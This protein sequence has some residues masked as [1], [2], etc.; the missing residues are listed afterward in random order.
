MVS[1]FRRTF[2][3]TLLVV[4]VVVAAWW[5]GVLDTDSGETSPDGVGGEEW[6][7]VTVYDGDTLLASRGSA[8]EKVRLIG[9]DAPEIGECGYEEARDALLDRV[10]RGSVVLIPGAETDRDRYERLLRYVE[11]DGEDVGLWLIE[12]GLAKARYDRRTGQPHD[13]E[14]Q[15]MAAD[16]AAAALCPV[17][18]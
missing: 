13:R 3:P 7:V 8:E 10:G 6:R 5:L 18:G 12:S 9:I 14:D 15:Y 11:V 17:P 16:D 4:A 1:S 2:L